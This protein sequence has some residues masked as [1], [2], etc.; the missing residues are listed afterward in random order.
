[1]FQNLATLVTETEI[2]ETTNEARGE[3]KRGEERQSTTMQCYHKKQF[4]GNLN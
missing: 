4:L 2:L 1:M 3:E